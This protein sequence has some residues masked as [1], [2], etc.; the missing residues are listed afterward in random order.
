MRAVR[1]RIKT[2]GLRPFANRTGLPLGQLR[3]VAE[4]R[5]A[6][7]P[8][9]MAMAS[10]VGMR[11]LV[12]PAVEE[13]QEVSP[14]A[15]AP[16]PAGPVRLVPF[17]ERVRFDA[18][19]GELTLEESPDVSIAVADR[20]LP[21]WARAGRL[22]CVQIAGDAMTP[23]ISRGALAVVDQN[24]RTAVHDAIFL[25][26]IGGEELAVKRLQRK[27]GGWMLVSDNPARPSTLMGEADLVVGRVAWSGPH[28]DAVG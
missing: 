10:A 20:V 1:Q 6:R 25:L 22:T 3:S 4:G 27:G 21:I 5:A 18:D 16:E 15:P 12:G 17:A 28:G 7:Y 2:E 13:G 8:T 9:L 19:A 14:P 23:T 26:C 11:L 24:S